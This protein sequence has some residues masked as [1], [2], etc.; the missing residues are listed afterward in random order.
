M[1]TL[2]TLSAIALFALFIIGS[3]VGLALPVVNAATIF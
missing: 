1:K 3:V 2:L